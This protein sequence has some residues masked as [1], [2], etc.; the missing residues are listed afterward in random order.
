MRKPGPFQTDVSGMG[1]ALADAWRV[2]VGLMLFS[3]MQVLASVFAWHGDMTPRALA[4]LN[5]AAL[6][7][8]AIAGLAGLLADSYR[9]AALHPRVR[10][11]LLACVLACAVT[12]ALV[13]VEGGRRVWSLRG[14]V[15]QG[16]GVLSAPVI[17]PLLGTAFLCLYGYILFAGTRK[18]ARL[19]LRDVAEP[20]RRLIAEL[21][22][23]SGMPPL[24]KRRI[25][26][27]LVT[28]SAG[29]AVWLTFQFANALF[30]NRFENGQWTTIGRDF[31]HLLAAFEKALRRGETSAVFL[32]MIAT[33]LAIGLALKAHAA[34][35]P[36]RSPLNRLRRWSKDAKSALKYDARRP[37]LLL[38]SFADET[39][40]SALWGGAK[41]VEALVGLVA[42]RR[43]PFIA[44][45]MPGEVAPSGKAYRSYLS[46]DQW[47]QAVLTWMDQSQRIVVVLGKTP[48]VRWELERIIE[49]GHL[50]KTIVVLTA[51][52]RLDL[53]PRWSILI[54]SA[55]H[56]PWGSELSELRQIEEICAAHF[57]VEGKVYCLRSAPD[58]PYAY[59]VAMRL[60]FQR[61]PGAP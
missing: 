38:R 58:S 54:E 28:G 24:A 46:D 60:A 55:G 3:G 45:G 31:A 61:L 59:E 26:A 25:V 6:A 49:R 15:A 11:V 1:Q 51:I 13:L 8:A 33:V 14:P 35:A 34:L 9:I 21:E 36:H 57:G 12:L 41:S 18:F 52:D 16:E 40:A 44:I 20:D 23:P 19:T 48:W 37:V 43:G 50:A 32:V 39:Q 27:A 17:I 5:D 10:R 29:V 2:R 56:T 30:R 7:R 4:L 53:A 47:Q 22:R 42:G